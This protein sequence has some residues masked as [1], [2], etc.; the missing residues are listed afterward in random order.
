[1]TLMRRS[2]VPLF[3]VLVVAGFVGRTASA[4]PAA[5]KTFTYTVAGTDAHSLDPRIGPIFVDGGGVE[6]ARPDATL[7]E[8]YDFLEVGLD[9]PVGAKVTSLVVYYSYCIKPQFAPDFVLGSYQ[10]ATG[11]TQQNVV[12]TGSDTCAR[13]ALTHTGKPILTTVA[14]RRYALDYLQHTF[15]DYPGDRRSVF[16]GATIKYTCTAPCVP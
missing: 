3:A 10:P 12:L 8:T 14:G 2:F 5:A 15:N 1:M 16:Y 6:A 11:S 13:S 4:S 7:P 9:L